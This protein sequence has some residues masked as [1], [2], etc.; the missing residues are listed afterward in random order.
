MERLFMKEVKKYIVLASLLTLTSCVSNLDSSS[1][2]SPSESGG[3]QSGFRT[4]LNRFLTPMVDAT[5]NKEERNSF[6]DEFIEQSDMQCQYYLGNYQHKTQEKTTSHAEQT[7]YMSIFDTVS[8]LFGVKYITDTAKEV[9]INSTNIDNNTAENQSMYKSALTPEIIRG[10]EIARLRYAT[11]MKKRKNETLKSYSIAE[12]QNDMEKYDKQCSNEYGLMEINKALRQAQ[13]QMMRRSTE[14]PKIDPVE[15]KKKVEV[16][17]KKVREE[18]K[19]KKSKE[20]EKKSI[21]EKQIKENNNSINS[22]LIHNE[23]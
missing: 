15:I 4:D 19:K 23:K 20:Q 14:A 9:F 6:L 5:S 17:T 13:N 11:A 8:L 12:L 22:R 10:V 3:Y 18:S 21:K 16:A 1:G 2:L 7:L